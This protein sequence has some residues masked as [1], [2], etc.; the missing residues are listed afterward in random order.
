MLKYTYRILRILL[1]RLILLCFPTFVTSYERY[2]LSH[3]SSREVHL[4]KA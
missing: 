1:Q 2:N 4:L 3:I